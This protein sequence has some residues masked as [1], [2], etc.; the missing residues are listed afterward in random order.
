MSGID[1]ADELQQKTDCTGDSPNPNWQFPS[2]ANFAAIHVSQ[3]SDS[4]KNAADPAHAVVHNDMGSSRRSD[5]VPLSRNLKLRA[6][7]HRGPIR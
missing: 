4:Q 6:V 3:L 5:G 2:S 1:E 7:H